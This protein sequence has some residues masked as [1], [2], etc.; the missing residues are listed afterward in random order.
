LLWNLSE[1]DARAKADVLERAIDR[2]TFVFRGQKV[3][4]GAS[5]GVAILGP[6]AQVGKAL[7]AADAAMYLRKAQRR[8]GR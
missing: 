7:E 4:A 5:A 1:S 8:R 6:D 2:L 3:S